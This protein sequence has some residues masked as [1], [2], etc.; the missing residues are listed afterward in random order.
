MCK[1][2]RVLAL[3]GHIGAVSENGVDVFR[4]MLEKEFAESDHG[5]GYKQNHNK[6]VNPKSHNFALL[7]FNCTF[8][9]M[10]VDASVAYP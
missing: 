6:H 3:H 5:A 9:K 2:P 7:L 1:I 8:Y 10:M 4:R